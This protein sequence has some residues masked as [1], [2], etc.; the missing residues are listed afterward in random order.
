MRPALDGRPGRHRTKEAV[1]IFDKCGV[2]KSS[3]TVGI[4]ELPASNRTK[5]VLIIDLDAQSST[6]GALLGR[7]AIVGALHDNQAVADL[8]DGLVRTR[9]AIRRMDDFFVDRPM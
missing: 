9:T 3:L 5:K 4:A 7:A 8:V 6:S 2:S 1:T